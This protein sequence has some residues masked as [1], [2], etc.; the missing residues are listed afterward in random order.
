MS[1]RRTLRVAEA[2]REVVSSAVL[3]ELADPRIKGVTVLCTEVTGDLRHATVY[4]SVMGSES[5]QRLA[6]RGLQHAAGFL[7]SKV[8]ARLQTRFTPTLTFK[9]DESVK[10]SVAISRLIDEALA[11]ERKPA[12][13]PAE[14]DGKDEAVD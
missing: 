7:Q 1:S 13:P 9:L 3:F 4:V 10:K 8:A 6:L 11:E 14:H 12:E 2:I 5:E